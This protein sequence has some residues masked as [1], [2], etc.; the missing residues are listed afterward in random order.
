[1]DEDYKELAR[2]GVDPHGRIVIARYGAGWRGLKPKL[3]QEHG[4]VGC[5][6]YS[7]PRDDGYGA[8]DVYP[9][10]GWRPAQGV[11]RGSVL[12]MPVYAGDPLTPGIGATDGAKRL[13]R[14][15]AKTILKSPVIPISY[16]DAKPLLAA[17]GGPIA[18]SGWRGGL[19]L[20]YHLG[21]GPAKVHLAIASDWSL[22]PLYDVIARIGGSESPDEWVVRGNHHDGWVAGAW[23]PLSGMVA[24]LAEAKAI[25]ALVKSGWRP[26]RTLVYAS[27]DGEEPGLLGSTEWAEAHAEELQKKAVLYL[28]TDDNGRGFL[29]AGG[30]HTL[31]R[32][33]NEVTDGIKDPETGV[34]VR[35]RLRARFMVDGYGHRLHEGDRRLAA[36]TSGGDL[37]LSALGSGSDFTPFIQHLGVTSLNF[38]YSGEEDQG[39][40]YHSLYDTFDHY[41]RFGDPGFVYGIALAQT[42]GHTLLRVAQAD[43]LPLEFGGFADTLEAYRQELHTLIDERR[44]GSVDLAKLL[45]EN[46]FKLAND[47]TRVVAPPEREPEV[48]YLNFASFDNAVARVQRQARAYDDASTRTLVS[49]PPLSAARRAELDEVLRGMEQ[50]LTDSRG[51]PGRPWYRHL[52]YAPGLLT[53]Y[54]VKTVPGVREAIE[55]HRWEEANDYLQL[56]ARVLETYADRLQRATQLF[57]AP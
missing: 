23:D 37:P 17:L 44:K 21:P 52:L 16:A 45:D 6:I 18:P 32:L 42:S 19:P 7:D 28:N 29:D 12:D 54:E 24:E 15:E 40:V 10:G 47:P 41:L 48:P 27:W 46:A 57:A 38:E 3:A 13:P 4:A 9:G 39:G 14:A 36:A 51:L 8:G 43:I 33:V 55:A 53:G 11:Q 30:S 25:G 50:T 1:M 2:R 35:A 5:I 31:Q 26:K 22:K 20:T 56:T 34:S 49:G